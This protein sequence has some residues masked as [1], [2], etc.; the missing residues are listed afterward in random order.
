MSSALAC[1]RSL[2]LTVLI[3]VT[4]A[5]LNLATLDEFSEAIQTGSNK[6]VA[7]LTPANYDAVHTVLPFNVEPIYCDNSVESVWCGS[8]L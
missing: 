3:R 5:E 4:A 7:F 6:K 8:R 2:L 1:V